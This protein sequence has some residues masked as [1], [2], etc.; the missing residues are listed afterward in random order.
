MNPKLE[1]TL[2]DQFPAL[3]G[4]I[5]STMYGFETEDGWYRLIWVLSERLDALAS[6]S[7][8]PYPQARQVKEKFGKLRFYASNLTDAMRECIKQAEQA[9]ANTCELCG[10]PGQLMV[11]DFLW[12]ARCPACIEMDTRESLESYG[13]EP[14]W[15]TPEAFM[16]RHK[17]RFN[18][19]PLEARSTLESGQDEKE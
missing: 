1:K 16:E 9:S 19:P 8:R 14:E 7:D 12:A 5:G 2:F 4:G 15:L 10:Q 6:E 13:H 11:N 18:P 3:Y 17:D